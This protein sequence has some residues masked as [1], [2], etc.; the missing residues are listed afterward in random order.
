M[1]KEFN[2][3]MKQGQELLEKMKEERFADV[4][5]KVKRWKPKDGAVYY[6]VVA[7]GT[8]KYIIWDNDIVDN[9][10]YKLGNCFETEEEAQKE[11]D[12]RIA[13]QE[14]LDM[15]DWDVKSV[16]YMLYSPISESFN[17]NCYNTLIPTPYRFASE[18]SAKKA[19]DTLGT[20][21]LKLIFRI[22]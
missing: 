18:E 19:I 21:K 13:E 16:Y 10:Y 9:G 14:L 15:C 3:L 2:Q 7:D 12:R 20:D 6:G 1:E 4:S 17:V 11:I 8:I 22:D 5:K